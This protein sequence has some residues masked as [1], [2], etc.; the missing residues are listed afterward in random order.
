MF[1][2]INTYF[3]ENNNKK[4]KNFKKMKFMVVKTY[5]VFLR[6]LYMH[7]YMQRDLNAYS[8]V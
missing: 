6:G 7:I 5:K 4:E 1:A 8:R 2:M 3:G